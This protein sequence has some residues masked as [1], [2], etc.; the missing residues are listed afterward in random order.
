M[1]G[2]GTLTPEVRAL[3]AAVQGAV[4]G[5]FALLA[6]LLLM[7]SA[8]CAHQ[9]Q[10]V[11]EM[12]VPTLAAWFSYFWRGQVCVRDRMLQP[13]MKAQP[14]GSLATSACECGTDATTAATGAQDVYKVGAGV[15]RQGRIHAGDED[16]AMRGRR[17]AGHVG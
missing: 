5:C 1:C 16:G 15:Q 17:A 8:C 6:S 7:T 10:L 9:T 13:Q 11:R 3:S 14:V 2:R 4:A 12:A